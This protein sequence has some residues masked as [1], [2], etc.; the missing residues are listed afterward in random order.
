MSASNDKIIS[1]L[2]EFSKLYNILGDTYR[3]RAYTNAVM[4]I[5]HQAAIG[6]DNIAN[7][8]GI[9]SGIAGKI[10]ELLKTGHVAELSKLSS[11]PIVRAHRELGGILGVGTQTIRHWISMGIMSISI[12]RKFIASGRVKLNNMQYYGL[13]YYKDLGMRIP[14]AEVAAIGEIIRARAKSCGGEI[15]IAGSY[16]RGAESSGDVDILISADANPLSC[17]KSSLEALPE[18]V[19]TI[20]SG[21]ERVSFLMR[22]SGVVRQV[23]LL[24]VEAASA[25]AALLYFTGSYEFNEY[26]RGVAKAQGY[27]LNQHGLFKYNKGKWVVIDTPTERSIFISLGIKYLSPSKR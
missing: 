5:K 15:I 20:Y 1:M 22:S 24:Y 2:K 4:E 19:A 27:K 17:M 23:D 10:V 18:Y 26:I 14:R 3:T 16:R 11:S 12:L 7:I 13:L 9:G 25:A 8:K 21:R 6:L